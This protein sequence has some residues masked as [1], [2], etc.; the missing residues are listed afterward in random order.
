MKKLSLSAAS[1][2]KGDVLTRGQL[3]KVLGGT[4]SSDCNLPSLCRISYWKGSYY[5]QTDI[6][7]T[8]SNA[9]TACLNLL[10]SG[11]ATQCSY[12]CECDGW[13]S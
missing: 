5:Y 9:N 2:K 13:G 7:G 12:D 10:S 1:I 11:A 3:K 8:S 4:S 6:I